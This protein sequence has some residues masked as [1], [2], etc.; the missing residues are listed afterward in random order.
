MQLL[1]HRTGRSLYCAA[2]ALIIAIFGVI[3]EVRAESVAALSGSSVI[4]FEPPDDGS[5][6]DSRGGASRPT[7]A[8]CSADSDYPV[9]MAALVPANR[10]GLTVKERPSFFVYL[11]ETSNASSLFFALKD[12]S[13]LGIYFVEMPLSQT[14]GVV[15]IS[16][17]ESVPPLEVGKTYHWIATLGCQIAQT[18]MPWVTGAVK[19]VEP[20]ST[21]VEELDNQPS[22]GQAALYA[23]AGI[24][25]DTLSSL[26][27]V[28]E[29]QPEDANLTA[30]W[31]SLLNSVGLNPIATQPLLVDRTVNRE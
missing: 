26:A 30:A 29:T 17:P 22:I 4:Q 20:D 19:R 24:W 7:Q 9:S 23:E 10:M 13:D 5:V 25:Y 1:Q 27:R 12:D 16:L 14:S 18:D 8:K 15:E 11:P 2:I 21:L 6:D 3:P 31:T 28:R